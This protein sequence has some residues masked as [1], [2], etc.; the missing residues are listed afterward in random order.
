MS[1]VSFSFA[2]FLICSL[3]S[4]YVIP[5][6]FQWIVLLAASTFFYFC[7]GVGNFAF[8]IFSSLTTFFAARLASIFNRR[9]AEKKQ[10]L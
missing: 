1:L 5:R 2:I 10:V 6:K 7:A 3:I 8:I 9:L 4:Y